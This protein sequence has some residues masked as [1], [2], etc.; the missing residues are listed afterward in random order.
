MMA[1][2]L[3]EDDERI[4]LSIALL[5]VYMDGYWFG[6]LVPELFCVHDDRSRKNNIVE[7]FNCWFNARC[8]GTYL[9]IWD[10]LVRTQLPTC[11]SLSI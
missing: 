5:Y 10:F 11:N 7:A 1:N 4:Q 2:A 8:G 9:N 6:T 3:L